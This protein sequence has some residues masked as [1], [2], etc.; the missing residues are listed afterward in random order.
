MARWLAHVARFLREEDGPAALEYA[1]MIGLLIASLLVVGA[2][3][4]LHDAMIG[5]FHTAGTLFS[6]T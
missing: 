4:G 2:A 6:M 1:L 3:T 5:L